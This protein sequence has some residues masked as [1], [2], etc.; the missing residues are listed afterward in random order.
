ML[1]ILRILAAVMA[2]GLGA[3]LFNRDTNRL[4]LVP[5]DR[6]MQ[7]VRQS[8]LSGF[9]AQLRLVARRSR[10]GSAPGGA[11]MDGQHGITCPITM[12][13]WAAGEAGVG[14][15]ACEAAADAAQARRGGRHGDA[16][17]GAVHQQN[18]QVDDTAR[19]PA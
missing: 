5:I 17:P 2:L 4:V 19:R 13:W 6:M 16:H 10:I 9:S 12:L 15:P 1:D 18:L 11:E 14:E 7:K 3:W 8:R